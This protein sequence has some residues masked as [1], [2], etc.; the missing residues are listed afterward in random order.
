MKFY[1]ELDKDG[2]IKMS[3]NGKYIGT[4]SNF[5]EIYALHTLI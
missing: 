3:I 1:Y 4:F 5:T 2:Q